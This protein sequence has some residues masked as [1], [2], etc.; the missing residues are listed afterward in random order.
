QRYDADE[1]SSIESSLYLNPRSDV[2]AVLKK[3]YT[4]KAFNAE[5]FKWIYVF[6]SVTD[7]LFLFLTCFLLVSMIGLYSSIYEKLQVRSI[8]ISFLEYIP[9]L[10][11]LDLPL[12]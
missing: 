4:T 6:N 2:V 3:N 9:A 11:I 7:E 10:F 5:N 8:P 12:S 1:L